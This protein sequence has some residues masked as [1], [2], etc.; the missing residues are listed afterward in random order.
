MAAMIERA[1]HAIGYAIAYVLFFR[2]K[3][4]QAVVRRLRLAYRL[5]GVRITHTSRENGVER[6][7]FRCPYRNLLAERYGKRWVCHQKLDRVDDG[8]VTYLRKHRDIEYRRP[9]SCSGSERCF[10]EVTNR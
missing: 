6:T 2:A 7:I 5:V 9:R 8:Y 4:P 10:S 1:L 3:T